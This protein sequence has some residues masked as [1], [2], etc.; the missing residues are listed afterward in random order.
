MRRAGSPAETADAGES[1]GEDLVGVTNEIG[2]GGS[3]E[4]IKERGGVVGGNGDAGVDRA[5]MAEIQ[6]LIQRYQN[7][8]TLVAMFTPVPDKLYCMMA[9]LMKLDFRMF[10]LISFISR[11]CRYFFTATL[12]FLYGE[13]IRDWLM[14]SLHWILL[15]LAVIGV[16]LYFMTKLFY[17]FL[18]RRLNLTVSDGQNNAPIRAGSPEQVGPGLDRRLNLTVSDG[19]NNAPIRAGSPEQV[20]PGLDKKLDI[21]VGDKKPQ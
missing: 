1:G 14:H 3:V 7:K 2:G 4:G 20:G 12:V 11:F 5:G 18:D 10:M 8:A 16:G 9:G 21:P 15:A 17:S 13:T 6:T 19:Q